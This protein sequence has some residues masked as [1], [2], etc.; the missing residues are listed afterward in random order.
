MPPYINVF[1][2]KTAT[3]PCYHHPRFLESVV[4]EL[5][6]C[7]CFYRQICHGDGCHPGCLSGASRPC[8]ED[9]RPFRARCASQTDV[10]AGGGGPAAGADLNCRAMD[11]NAAFPCG[12]T[13]CACHACPARYA[14]FKWFLTNGETTSQ[15]WSAFSEN[16]RLLTGRW[17]AWVTKT[18]TWENSIHTDVWRLNNW[19]FFSLGSYFKEAR[20]LEKWS[21]RPHCWIYGS[22]FWGFMVLH[23]CTWNACLW[24]C[25]VRLYH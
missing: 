15:D 5:T 9:G 25:L 19:S 3:S 16:N 18:L 12:R 8:G 14:V 17:D 20:F 1:I 4:T 11:G 10:E 23:T 21:C 6:T 2:W 7:C 13:T 22:L 24:K